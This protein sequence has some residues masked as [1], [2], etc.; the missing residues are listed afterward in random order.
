MV[1]PLVDPTG[2]LAAGLVYVTGGVGYAGIREGAL[3]AL[4]F[5][6]AAPFVLSSLLKLTGWARPA[7]WDP[8]REIARLAASAALAGAFIPGSLL[9]FAATSLLLAGGR[10]I[11]GGGAKELR[12]A[13]AAGVGLLIA[14]GLLLPWSSTWLSPGGPLN[15]LTGDATW[16]THAA[17]FADEGVVSVVLGQTPAIP[18][19]MG[20]ALPLLGIIAVLVGEGQRRR[21]A[22]ALWGVVALVG[23]FVS[24][25]ATGTIRPWFATPLEASVLAAAAFA[26][27]A[28]LAVGAFRLD[29]PRRG[30]GLVHGLAVT[31]IAASLFLLAAGAAPA[32]WNGD[33]NPGEEIEGQ[34]PET[35]EE[36]TQLL[37][38]EADQSGTFRALWIGRGWAGAERSAARPDDPVL[39]TGPRGQVLSD[40]FEQDTGEGEQVL[41]RI[42]ASVEDGGTDTGG[43]FLGAFDIRYVIVE[44]AGQEG[45]WQ[46]QRDLQALQNDPS[47]SYLLFENQAPLAAAGLYD[48]VP[49]SVVA[50]SA[51]EPIR[52][53]DQAQEPRERADQK[54]S[55]SYLA[56]DIEGPGVAFV[57]QSGDEGWTA[58]TDSRELD[59]A[60]GGWANAFEVPS[61]AAGD[62]EI[63]F[64]RDTTQTV[65][66]VI[67]GIAWLIVLG[68]CFSTSRR[69]TGRLR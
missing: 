20:L 48:E 13:I 62:L 67:V 59:E 34:P 26:G 54:T 5:A 52:T 16:E 27:L 39:V 46:R 68:A 58:S 35:K 3:G 4:V 9:L 65:F 24:L 29:L 61:E 60:D 63:S 17:R 1:T 56:D 33:W 2:R 64:D 30:L 22:L 44:K 55:S 7:A 38:A 10:A 8:G 57:P 42:I 36:I 37:S 15:R 6:A 23:F 45:A 41:D 21:A 51:S 25:F 11:V 43:A 69:P 50:A 18:A 47:L 40:L 19:L 53:D 12:T 49:P 28:G 32:I 14:W 31:G 66:L